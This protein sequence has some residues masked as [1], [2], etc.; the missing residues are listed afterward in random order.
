MLAHQI[1]LIV[2][3]VT[4]LHGTFPIEVELF[5]SA[6]ASPEKGV[7]QFL[8][9]NAHLCL[10]PMYDPQKRFIKYKQNDAETSNNC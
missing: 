5:F 7:R 4:W 9:L 1:K 8:P 3:F 6:E 2:S 10:T